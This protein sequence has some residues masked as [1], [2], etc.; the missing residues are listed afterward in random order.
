MD[1]FVAPALSEL[2]ATFS[3]EEKNREGRIFLMEK[4]THVFSSKV[5]LAA[6]ITNVSANVALRAVPALPAGSS[7]DGRIKKKKA[8]PLVQ[9]KRSSQPGHHR[10]RT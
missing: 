1:A 10:V 9:L 4:N 5:T 6:S 7:P 3:K 8:I 2:G